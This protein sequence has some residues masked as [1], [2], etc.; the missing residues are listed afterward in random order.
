MRAL[1]VDDSEQAREFLKGAI[2]AYSPAIDIIGEAPSVVEAAKKIKQL[3]PDL[4]FLDVQLND[5]DGFD[6]LELL[7]KVNFAI[8]FTTASD[9]HA[10]KAFKHAAVDYLLKPIDANQLRAAIERATKTKPVKDSLELLVDHG[11]KQKQFERIALHTQ[12]KIVVVDIKN[13]VRCEADVNYTCFYFNDKSKMMVTR[14]LKDFEEMLEDSGFARV[15]QS[16][17]INTRCIKEFIK[18][19]GGY[20]V[21]TDGSNVPVSIRKRNYVMEVLNNL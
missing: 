14:T 5:G 2:E 18:G 21:L 10:I 6:L 13:I 1:I 20:L 16:H 17:L 8:I 4:V 19:D 15:H 3:E 7:G 12:E 9:A 11:K